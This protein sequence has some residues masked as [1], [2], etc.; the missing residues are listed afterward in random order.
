[1]K[2]HICTA[3]L[4]GLVLIIFCLIPSQTLAKRVALVIGNGAYEDAPLRNPVNDARAIAATLEGVGFEVIS[5][6]DADQ[7]TMVR[8]ITSFGQKLNEAQAGLFYFAGHGVQAQGRNYLIP[9]GARV[10]SEADFEFEA[11]DANRVLRQME[12]A[13]ADV[14]IV[15]LDACRNNPFRSIFRST[16][17]DGLATLAAPRGTLLAYATSPHNVALDGTGL[18]SPYTDNLLR[19]LPTP[20]LPIEEVFKRVREGVLAETDGRQV[21]WESSSLVGRFYFI[22]PSQVS[23]A[24]GSETDAEM[25]FWESVSSS[26]DPREFEE[27][28]R[29]YPEGRFAGLAAMRVQG[30]RQGDL[31]AF[32]SIVGQMLPGQKAW[33]DK[34]VLYVGQDREVMIR[35]NHPVQAQRS[36][37]AD[38]LVEATPNGYVVDISR[39]E[40][41]WTPQDPESG[42]VP[43]ADLRL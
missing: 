24:T 7:R 3:F 27:Y 17:E 36:V 8:A 35:L 30:L 25:V 10:S 32:P 6:L 4:T 42:S 20:G 21:T 2:Q 18:H 22:S 11:V 29:L 33:A 13:R 38:V 28:L 37:Q 41:K 5:A 26:S 12:L 19:H 40:A 23:T 34:D 9:V 31:Q 15:I 39:T 14:N 1:M 16:A 43:A